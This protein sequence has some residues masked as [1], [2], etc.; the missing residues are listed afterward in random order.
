MYPKQR[1]AHKITDSFQQALPAALLALSALVLSACS[2][3]DPF[4]TEYP[5]TAPTDGSG[6]ILLIDQNFQIDPLSKGWGHRKFF[7]VAATKY[8]IE[9]LDQGSVLQC[10]TNNSGSILARH[11]DIPLEDFPIL[12]WS[13]KVEIPINSSLG[14]ATK[15]GDD[16]PA[17]LFLRFSEDNGERRGLEIVWSNQIYAPGDYKI[18]GNF[19]HYVANGLDKNVGVWHDQ[20]VD[21][22]QIYRDIGGTSANPKLSLLGFFCDSDNTGGASLAYFDKVRLTARR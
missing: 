18:I 16:H 9:R 13:W 4:A 20:S 1:A 10:Q 22:S 5:L 14:E 6:E 2:D 21:L 11:T 8:S 12:S 17:R 15:E 3:T 7:A 19:Y